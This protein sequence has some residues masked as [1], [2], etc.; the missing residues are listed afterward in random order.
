MQFL[1]TQF[2]SYSSSLWK[3]HLDLHL[4]SKCTLVFCKHLEIVAINHQLHIISNGFYALNIDSIL[5]EN[6]IKITQ[7]W[8]HFEIVFCWRETTNQWILCTKTS[9]A[10]AMSINDRWVTFDLRWL[11]IDTPIC[12]AF[13][14]RSFFCLN[15][16]RAHLEFLI[17][18]LTR[19][20]VNCIEMSDIHLLRYSV[21]PLRLT[22]Y[23]F[24]KVGL[25]AAKSLH[26]NAFE[27]QI[28]TLT[29]RIK[30]EAENARNSTKAPIQEVRG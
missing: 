14:R 24:T 6:S 17:F 8:W 2:I 9:H 26:L 21:R 16:C 5:T 25:R 30:I 22:N 28:D 18:T 12:S 11:F 7:K 10:Y 3:N 23:L 1:W 4:N 27:I 19:T 15:E 29:N 13:I 20:F